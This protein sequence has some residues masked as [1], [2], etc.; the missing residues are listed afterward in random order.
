MNSD[1]QL[2]DTKRLETLVDGIFAIAMTLLVLSLAV[3]QLTP[4]VTDSA[5]RA[6]LVGLIPNLIS[7]V[8]SFLL[9]SIFWKI[10]HKFFKQIEYINGTLLWINVI[11]LLFIV[12]VPF[13][14]TLTGDYGGTMT[15]HFVFNL[16]M[17]GIALLL[18]LNW[19]YASS[20]NFINENVD[21]K[22]ITIT[23][24]V[25]VAFVLIVIGAI[26]LSFVIPDYASIIYLLTFVVE[27]IVRKLS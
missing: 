13:S 17:M 27:N 12:L 19:H 1:N 23:W 9:L 11:W 4:P 18:F 7:M 2:M 15:A 14:E 10:H 24:R 6:A 16:N 26:L 22:E 25:N 21:Q 3:P 8:V 20:H 5:L